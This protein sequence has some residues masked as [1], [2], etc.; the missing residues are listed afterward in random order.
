MRGTLGSCQARL[1]TGEFKGQKCIEDA[2]EI[3]HGVGLCTR[4]R[5]V[6]RRWMKFGFDYAWSIANL[7]WNVRLDGR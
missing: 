5:N 2:K 3:V 6:L 4:H 7:E 1:S